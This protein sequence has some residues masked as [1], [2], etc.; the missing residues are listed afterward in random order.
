MPQRNRRQELALAL[1]VAAILNRD[2]LR[3]VNPSPFQDVINR[4]LTE[5]GREPVEPRPEPP[6]VTNEE[7]KT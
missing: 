5:C 2:G 4:L 6:T 7:E 1:Q 3:W